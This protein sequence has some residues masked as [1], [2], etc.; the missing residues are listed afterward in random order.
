MKCRFVGDLHYRIWST[1]FF[2][3]MDTSVID[4]MGCIPIP[5]I[6]IIHKLIILLSLFLI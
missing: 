3:D 1:C 2:S 4:G 6:A 5:L